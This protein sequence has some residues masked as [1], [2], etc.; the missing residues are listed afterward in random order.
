MIA[1]QRVF[2]FNRTVNQKVIW[3][4]RLR[5][6]GIATLIVFAASILLLVFERVRGARAIKNRISELIQ[7]GEQFEIVKLEPIRPTPAEDAAAALLLLTN[8]LNSATTNF[9]T[10]IPPRSTFAAPGKAVVSSRLA[11]WK[12]PLDKRT[13]N[14]WVAIHARLAEDP[15]LPEAIHAALLKSGWNDGFVYHKGFVDFQIGPLPH[16]KEMAL[17][18]E[19]C[20]LGALNEGRVPVA[21]GRVED[22]LRLV[23]HQGNS[24]LIISELVRIA[25]AAMSWHACWEIVVSGQSSEVQLAR[26]QAAWEG[27]NFSANMARAMEMERAM[28]MD[29]FE[30]MLSSPGYLEKAVN[31]AES[32]RGW[33]FG[34][35]WPTSGALLRQVHIPVWRFV[36]ARQDQLRS[37]NHLQTIIEFDRQVRTKSWAGLRAETDIMDA[38]RSWLF[39][40]QKRGPHQQKLGG[41]DRYRFLFSGMT[42]GI[43]SG[44]TRKAL[45]LETQRRLMIVAIAL[46]RHQL[47][48]S[49]F[50]EQLEELR[51]DLLASVPADPMDGK[52]MRYRRRPDGS[53]LLYS[54]G[55]DGQDNGGDASLPEGDQ[56]SPGIWRG[57]DAVW[58]AMAS[59]A[60]AEQAANEP[61]TRP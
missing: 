24:S 14:T 33:V 49:A 39:E 32:S 42:L 54:V 50:P 23:R 36:W 61:P 12:N 3:R 28:T 27:F 34:V 51:P 41:Y 53:P 31:Q 18:L 56:Q 9:Y 25:C 26:L 35:K 8:R 48:H 19:V 40:P 17:H 38:Q 60:E 29:Q 5:W 7:R 43:G 46:Q 2:R 44:A 4:L 22:M 15:N 55:F 10:M 30:Q 1:H 6:L 21:V 37:L 13:T 20:A 47:R 58:P 16:W 57:R 52:P 45:E 11:H 59:P